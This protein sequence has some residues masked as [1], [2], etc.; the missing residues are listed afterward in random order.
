MEVDLG[1]FAIKTSTPPV[2]KYAQMMIDDHTAADKDLV[3]F[4]KGHGLATIPAEKMD[5]DAER[6]AMKDMNDSVAK[7]KKLKGAD[8]DREYL[9][10][11]VNGHEQELAKSDALIAASQ[12]DD[13]DAVIEARKAVLTRHADAAKE[14]QKPNTQASK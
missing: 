2:K 14:L 5:T 13:L 3:T 7:M 8:F 4:S 12:N 9:R 6:T 11:M 10:M 1:K